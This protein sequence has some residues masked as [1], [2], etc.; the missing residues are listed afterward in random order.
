[1]IDEV[2]KRDE[3]NR[4]VKRDE[5][6]SGDNVVGRFVDY[7]DMVEWLLEKCEENPNIT[8]CGI[9]GKSSKGRELHY[10]RVNLSKDLFFLGYNRNFVFLARHASK[11]GEEGYNY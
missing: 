5:S 10:I 4:R 3:T 1:M 11:R 8:K 7:E 9:Y 6:G 2:E